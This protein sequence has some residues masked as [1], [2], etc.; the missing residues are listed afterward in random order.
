MNT[1]IAIS[2]AAPVVLLTATICRPMVHPLAKLIHNVL[3]L[4]DK[5]LQKR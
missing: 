4:V 2:F 1:I 5:V 3:I